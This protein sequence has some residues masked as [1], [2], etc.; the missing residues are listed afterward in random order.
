MLNFCDDGD[1]DNDKFK[2]NVGIISIKESHGDA[3]VVIT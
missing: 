1:R 3:T 2:I